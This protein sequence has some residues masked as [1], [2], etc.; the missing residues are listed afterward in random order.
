MRE[1]RRARPA[2]DF[3]A[4][5]R[6]QGLISKLAIE[7]SLADLRPAKGRVANADPADAAERGHALL[8][9]REVAGLGAAPT[10]ADR[11]PRV[12]VGRLGEAGRG[13]A[14][15]GHEEGEG[16]ENFPHR[17]LL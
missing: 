16:A 6:T 3:H 17:W 2:G 5:R 10:S 1:P 14:R 4:P 15:E 11:A 12:V 9:A 13:C 8:I 7:A